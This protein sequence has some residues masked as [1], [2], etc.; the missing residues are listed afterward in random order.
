MNGVRLSNVLGDASGVGR[1]ALTLIASLFVLLIAFVVG[2]VPVFMHWI[3]PLFL[4]G[5]LFGAFVSWRWPALGLFFYLVLVLFSPD[6]KLS[7]VASVLLMGLMVVRAFGTGRGVP[8]FSAEFVRPYVAFVGLFIIALLAGYFVFSNKVPLIYRDG[9]LLLYWLWIPVLAWLVFSEVIS[10]RSL[11]KVL[12]WFAALVCLVTIAQGLTGYQ[13]VTSGRVSELETMGNISFGITRVQLHGLV[14]VMFCLVWLVVVMANRRFGFVF[15]MLFLLAASLA[16]FM[17]YGRAVWAV[18]ALSVF[19]LLF[20]VPWASKLRIFGFG[21]ALFTVLLSSVYL[22]KPELI[23]ASVDRIV[24]V[25][26]EGGRGSSYGWRRWENE[27]ALGVIARSPLLGVGVGGEYRPWMSVLK[28]FEDHTRY[29]HNAYLFYAMKTG[30]VGILAL[31]WLLGFFY[32]SVLRVARDS[33]DLFRRDFCTAL[34]AFLPFFFLLSINQPE[35]AS[36]LSI[37][38]VA[39]AIVAL[40]RVVEGSDGRRLVFS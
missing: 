14:F 2:V 10:S 23:E 5:A 27:D 16:V 15:G 8:R 21:A 12:A 20:I 28:V 22:I 31:L 33:N 6:F 3:F 4:G 29:A 38:F 40:S 39:L 35:L 1:I 30:I 17:N 34:T 7:D 26:A 32:K 18:S 11:L 19:G 9:R 37:L 36:P 24:S 13:F 25:K